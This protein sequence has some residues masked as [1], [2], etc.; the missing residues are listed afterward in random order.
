[1]GGRS[2]LSVGYE[3][4]NHGKGSAKPLEPLLGLLP[5]LPLLGRP[6]RPVAHSVSGFT[7]RLHCG[8]GA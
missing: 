5:L 2:H 6:V 1:M 4:W 3:W 7:Q 8:S